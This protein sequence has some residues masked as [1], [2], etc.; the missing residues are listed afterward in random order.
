MFGFGAAL[1]VAWA[2]RANVPDP[3]GDPVRYPLDP[4]AACDRLEGSPLVS[5]QDSD[6]VSTSWTCGTGGE[7][8]GLLDPSS[9]C[10]LLYGDSARPVARVD[11]TSAS[12]DCL[13]PTD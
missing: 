7:T 12:W 13:V 8:D 9:A 5:V 10:R 4:V 1:L 3:A 11:T 2:A 6:L